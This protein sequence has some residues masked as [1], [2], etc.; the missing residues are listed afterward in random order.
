MGTDKEKHK[1]K[2][3]TVLPIKIWLQETWYITNTTAKL[4]DQANLYML[5]NTVKEER[6]KQPH[7]V[8]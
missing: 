7:L 1:H 4:H 6:R 5:I 8:T 2:T 3:D